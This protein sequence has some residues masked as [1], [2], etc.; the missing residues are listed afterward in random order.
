MLKKMVLVV[1][2]SVKDKKGNSSRFK[3]Y[4]PKS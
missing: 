3:I 1:Q 4:D 2:S